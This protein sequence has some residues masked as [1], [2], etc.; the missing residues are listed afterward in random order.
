MT[1]AAPRFLSAAFSDPGRMRDR[2]E[3]RVYCDDARGFFVVIDGMG[4]HAA[5]EKAAEIAL[6]RI[7]SR[8]ERQTDS[9]EQRV[10]EAITLANNAIYR[11]AQSRREWRG[12]ACVLTVAALHDGQA[13]VG[14]VG[15]SRL[16][17]IRRGQIEKIT[18]DH[19]PVGERE[20]RGEI[21]EREA[22]Q[23]PR[24]NEVFRD[25]GSTERTPDA[26]D[27]IEVQNIPIEPDCALL[28]C[29]DGLS[30][31]VASAEILRI[32][33]ANREDRRAAVHALIEAA[34]REGQDNVSAVLVAGEEF[35]P[36]GAVNQP[37]GESQRASDRDCA[38]WHSWCAA[39]FSGSFPLPWVTGGALPSPGSPRRSRWALQALRPLPP[40]SNRLSQETRSRSL[41]ESMR[42]KCV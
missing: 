17:K 41:P 25:V 22:M 42:N 40:L 35:A 32:V 28:L 8:L 7:R 14:H 36:A 13:T 24:R 29:S 39:S 30:D 3:D 21:S 9:I 6:E 31:V 10:R 27:F 4:G 38:T 5:G 18:H 2:N 11:A 26:D 12:M 34:S 19:S 1:P 15:D 23:H 33:E 20:D 16:Y 37:A